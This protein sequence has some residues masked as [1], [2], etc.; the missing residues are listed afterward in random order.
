MAAA[1]QRQ[2]SPQ[3]SL[4]AK[5]HRENNYAVRPDAESPPTGVSHGWMYPALPPTQLGV[6]C[7]EQCF[8][9]RASPSRR[10]M[11]AKQP[12]QGSIELCGVGMEQHREFS[13]GCFLHRA[14]TS[15]LPRRGGS[16][17]AARLLGQASEGRGGPSGFLFWT[18][19]LS[20]CVHIV[21]LLKQMASQHL[22]PHTVFCTGKGI[23]TNRETAVGHALP[24]TR[25]L[26]V[27]YHH[28]LFVYINTWRDNGWM[29]RRELSRLPSLHS[30]RTRELIHLSSCLPGRSLVPRRL[31]GP[32]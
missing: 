3:R 30:L 23:S 8:G 21:A 15:M 9:L 26:M 7:L 32:A 17:L 13:V 10:C 29:K 16:S 6:C 31:D 1:T 19:V 27:A 5:W 20:P 11:H 18:S 4:P 2:F 25:D 28:L 14:G 24:A 12:L 22:A